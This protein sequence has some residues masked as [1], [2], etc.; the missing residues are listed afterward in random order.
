M[1]ITVIISVTA[2]VQAVNYGNGGGRVFA[3]AP[4]PPPPPNYGPSAFTAM[5]APSYAMAA[6]VQLAAPAPAI[7]PVSLAVRSTQNIQYYDIPSVQTAA[8]PYQVMVESQSVPMTMMFRTYSS[9]MNVRHQHVTSQGSVQ[10]THSQDEPHVLRHTIHKPILQEIREVIA[11]MRTIRQEVRPVE[12]NIQTLV[13]RSQPISNGYG[14]GPAPPQAPMIAPNIVG[15]IPLA[16]ATGGFIGANGLSAA[17]VT[18]GGFAPSAIPINGGGFIGS[19]GFAGGFAAGTNGKY[20]TLPSF[21]GF[22]APQTPT[23][24]SGKF[25]QMAVPA[26]FIA[27]IGLA[28]PNGGGY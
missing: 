3:A 8:Q 22:A 1:L 28:A 16:P 7:S 19:A 17:P 15:G 24:F 25:G 12:E 26:A 4:P 18:F 27:P 6:P 13:A 21:A 5:A 11:P 2:A 14:Y 9:P 20:G 10:E 23:P